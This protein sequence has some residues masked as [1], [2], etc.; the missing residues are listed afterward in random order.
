MVL[1]DGCYLTFCADFQSAR[2]RLVRLRV[3]LGGGSDASAFSTDSLR[4]LLVVEAFL[5]VV[6]CVLGFF[7]AEE[8]F[9]VV[10][11]A[12]LRGEPE[13]F[14][15]GSPPVAVEADLMPSVPLSAAADLFEGLCAPLTVVLLF[16]AAVAV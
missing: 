13:D 16:G 9:S 3:S 15:L 6:R 1:T 14:G 12:F 11:V 2:F 8:V 10:I 7:E 4:A 5:V